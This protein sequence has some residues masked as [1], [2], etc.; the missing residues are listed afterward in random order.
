LLAKAKAKLPDSF[1]FYGR[2]HCCPFAARFEPYPSILP[3]AVALFRR[4]AVP[5]LD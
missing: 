4:S 1:W 5:D 3:Q 2:L